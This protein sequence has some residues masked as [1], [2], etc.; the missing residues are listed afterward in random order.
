MRVKRWENKIFS[1]G[2]V[3]EWFLLI[4][5]FWIFKLVVIFI[6][7]FFIKLLKLFDG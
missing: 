2:V 4:F 1:V 3:E 5:I 6:V 7:I